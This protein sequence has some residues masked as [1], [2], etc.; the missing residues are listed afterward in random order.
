V[1]SGRVASKT[2]G[3]RLLRRRRRRVR[4]G[5][6]VAPWRCLGG[7]KVVSGWCQSGVRWCQG[8]TGL[9][10]EPEWYQMWPGGARVP[11]HIESVRVVPAC[12]RHCTCR[13]GEP[14]PGHGISR[15]SGWCQ[16]AFRVSH[17][18]AL[19]CRPGAPSPGPTAPAGARAA[20]PPVA[21][22]RDSASVPISGIHCFPGRIRSL[23]CCTLATF[24]FR[25]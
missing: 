24:A 11:L 3:T 9:G 2:S 4:A 12:I 21:P 25:H 8:G 1:V 23:S 14:S 18:Q 22:W 20:A 17:S 13:P 5:A 19:T 6:R 16:S 7:P 15:V 10:V